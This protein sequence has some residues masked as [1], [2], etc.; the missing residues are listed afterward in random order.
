MSSLVENRI[1][2]QQDLVKLKAHH[3]WPVLTGIVERRKEAWA[4]NLAKRLIAGE[5]LDELEIARRS[6][7]FAG[8]TWLL[9]IV[10][11]SE[12]EIESLLA[13]GVK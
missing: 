1:A 12:K 7:F 3:A 10:D 6:G 13:K 11:G 4:Q 9:G 2:E 5:A 8:A